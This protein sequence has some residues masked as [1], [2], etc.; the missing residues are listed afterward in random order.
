MDFLKKY[1]PTIASLAG[2]LLTFLLPSLTTEAAAHPKT[3]IG[4]LCACVIAAYHAQAP[5]DQ[6]DNLLKVVLFALCLGLMVQPAHAQDI[7]NLY[8]AGISYNNSGSPSVAGTALYAHSLNSSGTYAFTIVDALPAGF[9]PFT[10]T[11]SFGG[12]VAQKVFSIGNVPL[13]VPT[14]AGVSYNGTNTGWAWG[15]GAM[16]S[17]HIKGNWYALPHARIVKSSVSVGTSYQPIVGVLFG[18]GK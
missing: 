1:W 5:R 10:V 17:I 18:W 4:I 11:T 16:A 15:T 8:A 12:G 9:K 13:Y 2:G 14:S 6:K 7:Q 3:A